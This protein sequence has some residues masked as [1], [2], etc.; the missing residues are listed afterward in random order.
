MFSSQ[1]PYSNRR[2]GQ[3]LANGLVF[4][5]VNQLRILFDHLFGEFLGFG[6]LFGEP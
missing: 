2:V 5:F 1:L 6:D 3:W 4:L